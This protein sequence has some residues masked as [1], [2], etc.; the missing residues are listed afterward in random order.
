MTRPRR[1]GQSNSR[2]ATLAESAPTIQHL[3]V[4]RP[5]ITVESN[6]FREAAMSTVQAALRSP[7][8][9]DLAE[10][11]STAPELVGGKAANLGE[12]ISSGARV[13]PGFCVTTR[14]YADVA[15]QLGLDQVIER[16]GND[17]SVASEIRAML[18]NAAVP[19]ELSSALI[20]AYAEMGPDVAVA[21]RSSATAEDLPHASFAGQQ[22][23]YLNV[24][25][26]QAL[27]DAV[28]RCWSSLW[29]DRAVSYRTDNGVDHRSVRLAVVV[30]R[31]VDSASSGVLFTAN[32]ISGRRREAVID[33]NSGLG[34]SVVSGAVDPD[35]F[36]VDTGSATIT[37][38][39]LG[40]KTVS[41]RS[42]PG[43]GTEAVAGDDTSAYTLTDD[44]VLALAELGDAAER[45]F[46]SPQDLEWAVDDEGT[47]WL[48][49][50]R[51]ITTLF[52]LPPETAEGLRAYFSINVAQGVYRPITPMGAS[53]LRH[54]I[55]GIMR[56]VGLPTGAPET[57]PPVWRQVSGWLFFD[58]TG[59]LRHTWGRQIAPRM[60][61]MM[62]ARSGVVFSDLME[63]PEFSV[64]ARTSWPLLRR[65]AHVLVTTKL[66]LGALRALRNPE[67]ARNAMFDT[68]DEIRSALSARGG[69]DARTRLP[70]ACEGM[71]EVLA[72]R[73]IRLMPTLWTGLALSRFT[74]ALLGPSVTTQEFQLTL[75]GIPNNITTLMDLELWTLAER[76]AAD[77]ETRR[78]FQDLTPERLTEHYRNGTLPGTAAEELD[79]FLA[80]YGHRAVAEIDT[81]MPRWS[82]EPT[83]V[84]G[85]IANYLRTGGTGRSAEEQ[86]RQGAAEAEEAVRLIVSRLRRTSKL[87][88]RLA[89][90]ALGRM[91]LLLGLREMPKFCMVLGLAHARSQLRAA[92]EDLVAEGR[93]D[94]ADDV[95][96]LDLAEAEEALAGADF[97]T[98]VAGRREV[99]ELEL[100]R[101]HLPRMLLSDGT[102]PET[103]MMSPRR[104][105][106]LIGASASA[107]TATGP[108]RVVLD[109]TGARI[110]P[111]EIL[112][113][114]STDPGWTPL[115]LTAAGLVMEMGGPNSHGAT[116]AREYG[117]PAVVGV[118]DATTM[119]LSGQ[120]ITVDGAA[121]TVETS[122][123]P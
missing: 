91:R 39:T 8:L 98:V 21:V 84:I 20:R 6:A 114:P 9:V 116:V 33:A 97:R 74:P 55:A 79:E 68:V 92:G 63:R 96:F 102:E 67:R 83:H 3:L 101:R 54:S 121:G 69:T 81:G 18:A 35:R 48:T 51:P 59:I 52:P 107:G 95:F 62:E 11:G 119:I 38:R 25:G 73:M 56:R 99:H 112:V 76:T 75:R 87:R 34:E 29:T 43:G 105:G 45:H 113:A 44:Q 27:L 104:E 22:D 78:M 1:L 110:E 80:R 50:S 86:Y 72:P 90:F 64:P 15:D 70:S 82:E 109:P 66:P 123:P 57:T 85:M 89:E 108:A 118:P 4:F 12:L 42:K 23:T 49:Q 106:T 2:G 26:E 115:F 17:H 14:A 16:L 100:R 60:L 93:L 103:T 88:A 65:V 58:V 111:G 117:I 36:V 41:V 46:G 19:E 77:P 31:M 53:V 47:C 122:P 5:G 28:R 13:P 37:S 10:A 32:P 71:T 120:T 61:A 24:V 30:Q 7:V 94:A 40:T